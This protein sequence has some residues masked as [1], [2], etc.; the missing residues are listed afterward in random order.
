MA[1]F[2][3]NAASERVDSGR[4]QENTRRD[5]LRQAAALSAAWAA[6][7]AARRSCGGFRSSSVTS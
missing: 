3:S 1:C 5:F 4:T 2:E 6:S 7:Q